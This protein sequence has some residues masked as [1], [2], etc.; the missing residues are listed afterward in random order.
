MLVANKYLNDFFRFS[1][2]RKMLHQF[3]LLY[4]ILVSGFILETSAEGM[5][6]THVMCNFYTV[7][8]ILNLLKF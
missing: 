3:I 1:L 8:I 2:H 4:A 6:S 5:V 7:A